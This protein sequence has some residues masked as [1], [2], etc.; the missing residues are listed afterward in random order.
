VN[1]RTFI[2]LAACC[3]SFV[4]MPMARAQDDT[5][6]GIVRASEK[7]LLEFWPRQRESKAYLT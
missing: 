4:A 7:A 5:E 3:V 2:L 1:K 6:K